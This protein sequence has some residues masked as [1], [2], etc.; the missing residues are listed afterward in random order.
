MGGGNSGGG[1]GGGSGKISYPAYMESMHTTWLSDVDGYMDTAIAANPFSGESAYDP[2]TPISDM[3]T[4]ICAFDAVVDAMAHEDDWASAFVQAITYVDGQLINDNS[5]IAEAKAYADILDFE[6]Q[7][8]GLP[9]F[10]AGMRDIGAVGSS[11]Y[12]IGKAVMYVQ[13]ARDVAKHVSEIRVKGYL[14]R[15][16]IVA[17]SAEVMLRNLVSRVDFESRVAS[18]TTDANRIEIVAKK[19]ETDQNLAIDEAEAKWALDISMYGAKELASIGGGVPSTSRSQPSQVQSALGG[20]LAGAS[21]GAS[22]G[23]WYGAAIGGVIGLG[24]ALIQ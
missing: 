14:Q 3:D 7:T 17:R 15:N 5:F 19:E 9:Q 23:G 18:L 6:F 10:E 21:V 12:A 2:T 11:S 8:R 16:E 1:G 20:A 13:K 24:A 4:A 22:V